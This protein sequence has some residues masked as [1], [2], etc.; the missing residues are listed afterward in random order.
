MPGT[1]NQNEQLARAFFETMNTGD[2]ERVRSMLHEQAT[3]TMMTNALPGPNARKGRNAII[4]EFLGP[5][6][7]IF[8]EGPKITVERIISQGPLLAVEAKGLG[9]MK[10]GKTYDNRYSF[11]IEIKDGKIFDLREYMD[12]AHVST[13]M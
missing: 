11:I 5:V 8:L 9:R 4:D 7:G 13:L 12:S 10:N 2:L 3:W 6:R 1:E